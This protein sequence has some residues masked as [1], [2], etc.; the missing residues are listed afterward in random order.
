LIL[1]QRM[2][3]GKARPEAPLPDL[4]RREIAILSTLMAVMIWLGLY[5]RPF[6]EVSRAP[7][8]ALQTLYTPGATAA[9]AP[10]IAR[11]AP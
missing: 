7:M 6:F 11:V 2:F 4:D 10:S 9:N 1:M 3:Y 8:Q 5:P